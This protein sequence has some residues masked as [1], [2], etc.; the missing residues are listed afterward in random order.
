MKVNA[1]FTGVSNTT[2]LTMTGVPGIAQ[3]VT[4]AKIV[5][6]YLL[7][8]GTLK[9]GTASIGLSGTIT[10]GLGS[11][12]TTPFTASGVKGFPPGFT[13]MFTQ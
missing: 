1:G 8:N 11:D 12:G 2:A 5:P 10:F 3:A 13:L 9:A 6:C 4:S 7:D